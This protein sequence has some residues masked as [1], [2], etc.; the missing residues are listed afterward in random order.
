MSVSVPFISWLE[1][2]TPHYYSES[3]RVLGPLMEQAMEKAHAAATL[4]AKQQQPPDP[5][6]A[7]EHATA[8]RMGRV[9]PAARSLSL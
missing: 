1:T 5:V 9:S 3:V 7:G 6:G 4:V 8:N 2:N